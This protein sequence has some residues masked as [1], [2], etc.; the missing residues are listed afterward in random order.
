MMECSL[1]MISNLVH[2]LRAKSSEAMEEVVYVKMINWKRAR[3]ED[4]VA[5]QKSC[6]IAVMVT[7]ANAHS[8][9]F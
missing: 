6:N 2:A 7:V 5:I 4:I 1:M 8:V 9:C 3:M